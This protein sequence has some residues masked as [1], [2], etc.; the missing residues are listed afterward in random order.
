MAK[1]PDFSLSVE[2]ETGLV[3]IMDYT[4]FL[5]FQKWEGKKTIQTNN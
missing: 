1:D 4:I 5:C 3:N 2:Q